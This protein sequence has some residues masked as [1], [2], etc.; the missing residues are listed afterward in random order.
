MYDE[1]FI[2]DSINNNSRKN[3]E[4]IYPTKSSEEIAKYISA[5]S[6]NAGG[7]ILFGVKDTGTRLEKKGYNFNIHKTDLM[8]FV[9]SHAIFDIYDIKIEDKKLKYIEVMPNQEVVKAENV[10]YLIHE[11][12]SFPQIVNETKLFLS[13]CQK[14]SCIAD[15]IDKKL[16]PQLKY[17]KI[18]RDIRDTNYKDSFNEFM[19][20]IDQHDFVLTL[21]SD[22]YL[23]SRNCMYEVVQT[24]KSNKYKDKLHFIIIS[25]QDKKYYSESDDIGAKIYDVLGQ[26]EYIKY[27]KTQYEDISENITQVNDPSL[28]VKLSE[29]LNI[30]KKIQ[31]DIQE[32]MAYL[33]DAK[34]ITFSE[35]MDS[36]F[37]D[38]VECINKR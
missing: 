18:T 36:S 15:L 24:L 37:K 10:M 14:D 34:G 3:I 19:N 29:E 4:Y 21:V 17:T 8:K 27:W 12:K 23:K 11:N 31:I 38:I 30:I 6:N 25:D 5:F 28:T 16:G 22:K 1:K 9:D 7:I 20:S 13:Y 35:M 32:F 2:I 33:K 26:A